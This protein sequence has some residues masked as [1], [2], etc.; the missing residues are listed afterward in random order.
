MQN[1]FKLCVT[2]KKAADKLLHYTYEV[3]YSITKI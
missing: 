2:T 1:N 3:T